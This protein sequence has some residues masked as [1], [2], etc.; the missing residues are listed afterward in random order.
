[1]KKNLTTL[2]LLFIGLSVLAQWQPQGNK[3]KTKWAEEVNPQNT[4]PEYPRPIM[5]RTQWKNLNG[6]WNYTIQAVGKVAPKAYQGKILVPFAVESSLSGVM[7]TVGSE[8]EI[9]YETNFTVDNSWKSKDILLHFGAVDWKT[10]VWINDI[11]VGT[12]TGGF[13]PFSFNITPFLKGTNQKLVVKVWD[14][15]SDGPQ[16]RGK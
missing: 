9:W 16:P 8:N 6:L 4:L 14:P 1:M 3:L 15:T 5:E 12:H 2:V 7:K 13:T 10:E 11:K